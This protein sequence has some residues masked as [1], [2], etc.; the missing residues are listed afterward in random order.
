MVAG[1]DFVAA[2]ILP[3]DERVRR[4]KLAVDLRGDLLDD[5]LTRSESR[6]LG[7]RVK[8]SEWDGLHL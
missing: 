2:G 4:V 5:V 1:N 7:M 3:H 8:L 6:I